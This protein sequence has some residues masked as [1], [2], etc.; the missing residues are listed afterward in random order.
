M[1]K[2]LVK[3]RIDISENGSYLIL[4]DES[5]F[6]IFIHDEV[7]CSILLCGEETKQDVNIHLG[8]YSQLKQYVFC[9][10]SSFNCNV[11]LD[12]EGAELTYI[13]SMF[14]SIKTQFHVSVYHNASYTS[15]S[16]YNHLVN[17]SEDVSKIQVDAYV[18]CD[19][20]GCQLNQDNRIILLE[21]GKG[22]ILPNLYIDSFDSFAEHSAYISKLSDSEMFYLKSRGINQKE[23]ELLL[24]KSFLLGKF[25]L[26]EEYMGYLYDML[27]KWKGGNYYES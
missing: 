8:R 1:N 4:L 9:R 25:Q 14:A 23:A 16:F 27:L 26:E 3:P 21:N 2:I 15:S 18:P 12:E 19:K 10:D 24:L 6:E 11:Y 7:E 5:S 17:V 22:E 13:Y 20:K